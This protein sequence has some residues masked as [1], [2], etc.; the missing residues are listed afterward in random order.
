MPAVRSTGWQLRGVVVPMRARGRRHSGDCFEFA[1]QS[2]I[3][4]ILGKRSLKPNAIEALHQV[5]VRSRPVARGDPHPHRSGRLP[6]HGQSECTA[7]P[8]ADQHRQGRRCARHVDRRQVHC[9]RPGGGRAAG[10]R[11]LQRAGRPRLATVL[12]RCCATAWERELQ[13]LAHNDRHPGHQNR[14]VAH[15][16]I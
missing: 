11:G 3:A 2:S 9:G 5:Q 4:E 8:L 12:N 7:D 10:R 6:H 13:L 15:E 16:S 14:S 1:S